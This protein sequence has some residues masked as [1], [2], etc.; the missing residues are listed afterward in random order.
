[1][2]SLLAQ[3]PRTEPQNASKE[4]RKKEINLQAKINE[5]ENRKWWFYFSV[6]CF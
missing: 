6:F 4:R 5:S 3:D 1:M 2:I